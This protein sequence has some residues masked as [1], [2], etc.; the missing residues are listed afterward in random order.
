MV[1]ERPSDYPPQEFTELAGSEHPVLLLSGALDPATPIVNIELIEPSFPN[2]VR[3]D[4]ECL[5]HDVSRISNLANGSCVIE[6]ARAFLDDPSAEL[7][8]CAQA[9]CDELP[10]APNKTQLLNLIG[11]YVEGFE[12]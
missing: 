5:G 8:S 9:L 10:L 4:F 6:Q 7:P 3:A 11:D 1:G 2:S 12:G